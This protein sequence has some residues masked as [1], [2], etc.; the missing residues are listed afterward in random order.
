MSL[1]PAW[2]TCVVSSRPAMFLLPWGMFDDLGPSLGTLISWCP[3]CPLIHMTFH[4]SVSLATTS[5]PQ[6]SGIL[7]LG[8]FLQ[9][10]VN[11]FFRR[12]SKYLFMFLLRQSLGAWRHELKTQLA[13]L[14]LLLWFVC[15][16]C[17]QVEGVGVDW[18]IQSER[19][20]ISP[21]SHAWWED[22]GMERCCGMCCGGNHSLLK[23][24]FLLRHHLAH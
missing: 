9:K 14:F 6:P 24:P 19:S 2:A 12:R 23:I 4:L 18:L 13:G 1:R 10:T 16:F 8:T 17:G 5:R 15:L 22:V 20:F 7:W 3:W 21:S 11:S